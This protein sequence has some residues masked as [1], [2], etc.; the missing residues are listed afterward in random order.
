LSQ[1][2][3]L[4]NNT[5]AISITYQTAWN[6]TFFTNKQNLSKYPPRLRC[7]QQHRHD[8]IIFKTK[9][10]F[11]EQWLSRYNILSVF[12]PMVTF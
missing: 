3:I 10:K 2:N 6:V 5:S 9:M 11:S 8:T 12:D 7:V 4:E 1:Y